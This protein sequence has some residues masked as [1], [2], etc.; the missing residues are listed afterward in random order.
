MGLLK[1]SEPKADPPVAPVKVELSPEEAHEDAK[2]RLQLARDQRELARENLV[3]ADKLVE[4]VER[5]LRHAFTRM[6]TPTKA[7]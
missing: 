3:F 7:A 5:E 4:S 2:R 1:K 6:P